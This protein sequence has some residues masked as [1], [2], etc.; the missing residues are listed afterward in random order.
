MRHNN[1]SWKEM[2]ELWD[3]NQGR[4]RWVMV[5]QHLTD[6][7]RIHIYWA[8]PQQCWVGTASLGRGFKLD[9]Q[10][11]IAPYPTLHRG[12]VL[13][14]DHKHETFCTSQ[15]NHKCETFH[16]SQKTIPGMQEAPGNVKN[17]APTCYVSIGYTCIRVYLFHCWKGA[18]A[19]N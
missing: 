11:R 17:G 12:S 16:T 14:I 5:W 9:I 15:N 3:S 13:E 1:S 2:E 8:T 19:S 10:W 4:R 6:S 7:G 18:T